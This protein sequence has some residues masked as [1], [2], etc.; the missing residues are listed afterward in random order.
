MSHHHS[1]HSLAGRKNVKLKEEIG[2]E[3]QQGSK[4]LEARYTE[5]HFARF[6]RVRLRRSK[7]FCD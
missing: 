4:F 6:Q 7:C 2:E 1:L 3:M 5:V